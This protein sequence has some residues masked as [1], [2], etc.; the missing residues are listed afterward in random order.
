MYTM[1]ANASNNTPSYTHD[2]SSYNMYYE[3][4]ISQ[5]WHPL[6]SNQWH[7]YGNW[8]TTSAAYVDTTMTRSTHLWWPCVKFLFYPKKII[9]L[10]MHMNH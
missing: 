9:Q 3:V 6:T 4:S 8:P 7:L 1:Y 5:E 2:V 10:W